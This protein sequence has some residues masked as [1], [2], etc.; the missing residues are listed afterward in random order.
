MEG[1]EI[2]EDFFHS[3]RGTQVTLPS[4]SSHR[5]PIF[6][7]SGPWDS[8]RQNPGENTDTAKNNNI[9]WKISVTNQL[10]FLFPLIRPYVI[11]F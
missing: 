11:P 10:N 1:R 5:D 6:R 2:T 4:L 8:F 7:Q 9:I 3:S